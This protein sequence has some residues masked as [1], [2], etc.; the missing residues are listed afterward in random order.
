M[1]PERHFL[2]CWCY[3]KSSHKLVETEGPVKTCPRPHRQREAELF[4][5]PKRT[6]M[7]KYM[8]KRLQICTSSGVNTLVGHQSQAWLPSGAGRAETFTTGT[9]WRNLVPKQ[10]RCPVGNLLRKAVEL[11]S[12]NGSYNAPGWKTNPLWSQ[13]W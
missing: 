9:T 13:Q 4:P 6:E 10:Q 3:F 1:D 2:R 5:K 12:R 8:E 7:T 11:V